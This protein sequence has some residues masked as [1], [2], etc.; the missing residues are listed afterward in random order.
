MLRIIA[1]LF[2]VL[3]HLTI[4]NIGLSAIE[5]HIDPSLTSQ[6]L[7]TS[8]LDCFF[9]IGVNVFF[10][11]SGYFGIKLKLGKIFRLLF[12]LYV[13]W[14]LSA[15]IAQAAGVSDFESWTDCIIKC[16]ISPSEY[17]FVL[18]YIALCPLNKD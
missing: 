7:G 3:H 12:K 10:L 17:W 4:N 18:A 1:M 16:L 8:F 5:T 13:F 9:I 2:I 11:L 14:I 15:L 6:Y